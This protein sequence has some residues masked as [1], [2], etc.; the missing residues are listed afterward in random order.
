V[1]PIASATSPNV[2]RTLILK[3]IADFPRSAFVF[4]RPLV[5][6]YLKEAVK[7]VAC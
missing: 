4:E 2:N 7:L 1:Q 5:P 3:R 6:W